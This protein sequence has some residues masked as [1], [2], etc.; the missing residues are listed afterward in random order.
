MTRIASLDGLRA[1]SVAFVLLGHMA[2]VDAAPAPLAGYAHLGVEVFFVISGFIIT[3]LL[4]K[5]R[6]ET[7]TISL[8]NFY[9]RRFFRIIPACYL[10]VAIAFALHHDRF[11]FHNLV[12]VLGFATNYDLG[13]P[14]ALGHL[15]SLAVEEQFYLLWPII[16]L[17]FFRTRKKIILVALFL[18]PLITLTIRHVPELKSWEGSLLANYDTLAMGCLGALAYESLSF[19]RSRWFILCAPAAI[20]LSW[21]AWGTI[22]FLQPLS[23]L[24][25]AAFVIHATRHRYLLLNAAPLVW[26]GTISYGIYLWQ[27]IFLWSTHPE[28][29]PVFSLAAACASYYGMERPIVQWSRASW[30]NSSHV[31][32]IAE[33]T[34]C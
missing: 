34:E 21:P 18:S 1:Y 4:L 10:Y 32:E 16:L 31:I 20:V 9:R 26:I 15:W 14:P 6:D 22:H 2:T 7:G 19:L 13:R 30:P 29:S 12:Y 24:C 25:I 11:S 3:W 5:E 28:L 8:G 33:A 27:S 23:H 17:L